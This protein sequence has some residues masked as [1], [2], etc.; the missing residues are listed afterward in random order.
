VAANEDAFLIYELNVTEQPQHELVVCLL[1]EGV[2]SI[3]AR[4]IAAG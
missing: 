3:D 4:I 2:A 1:N